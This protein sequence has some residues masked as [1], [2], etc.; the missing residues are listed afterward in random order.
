MP[1]CNPIKCSAAL[2]QS[3][4]DSLPPRGTDRESG[5]TQV[6]LCLG[7]GICVVKIHTIMAGVTTC[8]YVCEWGGVLS[9]SAGLEL[10]LLGIQGDQQGA[11]TCVRVAGLT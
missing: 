8:V 2:L 6:C 11:L 4:Y 3:R 10:D 7:E 9:P 1:I 5:A